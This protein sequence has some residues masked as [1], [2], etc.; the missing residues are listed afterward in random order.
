MSEIPLRVEDLEPRS[1]WASVKSVKWIQIEDRELLEVILSMPWGDQRVLFHPSRNRRSKWA[2]FL[3][4]CRK[5]DLSFTSKE[6]IIKKLQGKRFL[7]QE[8]S[9]IIDDTAYTFWVPIRASEVQ[10]AEKSEV[11]VEEE[12]ENL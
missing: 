8:K 12:L 11:D 9:I 5:C 3:I 10:K 2:Y 4:G 6:D 1:I 7:W